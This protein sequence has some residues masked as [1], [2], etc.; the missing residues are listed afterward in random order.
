MRMIG[1]R[2]PVSAP[3]AGVALAALLFVAAGIRAEA[4]A[5]SGPGSEAATEI[6]ELKDRALISRLWETLYPDSALPPGEYQILL[7]AKPEISLPGGEQD[8]GAF[9]LRNGT[10]EGR[11]DRAAWDQV[12]A[13]SQ[14][15]KVV[16]WKDDWEEPESEYIPTLWQAF[17]M[18]EERIIRWTEWPA[19]VRFEAGSSMSSVPSASPQF[20]RQMDFEWTQKLY[21]HFLLGV[22]IHRTE[23]GGGLVRSDRKDAVTGIGAD[24]TGPGFWTD[25]YWWW[26]FSAGVPGARY[27]LYLADRPLPPFFWL[28]T[29]ASSLIKDRK[30]GKVVKQW[31]GSS[32]R[33][34]GNY[35]QKLDLRLAYVRYRLQWDSDAYAAPLQAVELDDLPAFFGTWGAGFITASDVAATR[36]WLDIPDFAFSLARPTAYPSRFRFAFLRFDLAYR[37]LKSFHLGVSVTARLENPILNFP[38]AGP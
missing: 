32:L 19:G 29:R 26:S 34:E 10:T 18:D 3:P 7:P 36:V 6:L 13:Y 31:T 25:P 1:N 22:G 11:M 33:R 16:R 28:E 38:G 8:A 27:T 21:R 14:N 23:F 24:T 35:G 20:E 4:G 9:L 30:A 37:N 5:D 2:R 12:A 15:D 17:R